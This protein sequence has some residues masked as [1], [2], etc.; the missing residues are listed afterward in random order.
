MDQ[1]IAPGPVS[2]AVYPVLF[3]GH[4]GVLRGLRVQVRPAANNSNT[5]IRIAAA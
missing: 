4:D 5:Q 1:R 3:T 2:N